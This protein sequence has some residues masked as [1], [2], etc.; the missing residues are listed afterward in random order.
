[1]KL[2]DKNAAFPRR[3]IRTNFSN[4]LS[5]STRYQPIARSYAGASL[6]AELMIN[7]YVNHLPFYRQ[8]QMMKQMGANMP[9]PAVNDC[10]K[11]TAAKLPM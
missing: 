1:M 6:L 7:K 11:D 10:F 8:I 4:S 5:L 3:K 9:P 2:N